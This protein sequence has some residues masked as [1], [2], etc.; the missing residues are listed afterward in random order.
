MYC[1]KCHGTSQSMQPGEH[2]VCVPNPRWMDEAHGAVGKP[3]PTSSAGEARPLARCF[4]APE[5]AQSIIPFSDCLHLH[6]SSA[7]SS[8]FINIFRILTSLKPPPSIPCSSPAATLFLG[9]E[10]W[11]VLLTLLVAMERGTTF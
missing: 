1:E 4:R 7:P 5:G 8:W 9:R 11:W 3:F 2:R 6:F 10:Y